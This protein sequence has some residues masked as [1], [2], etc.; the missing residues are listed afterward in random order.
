MVCKIFLGTSLSIL[1]S[2]RAG[3]PLSSGKPPVHISGAVLLAVLLRPKL[4]RKL[5]LREG[6]STQCRAPCIL[7]VASEN[8][9]GS[10]DM[11][12]LGN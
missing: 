9:I 1:V 2:W 11:L 3:S 7:L 4:Q 5:Q 8:P 6:K 10:W 12:H